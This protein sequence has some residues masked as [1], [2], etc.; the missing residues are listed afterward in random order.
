ML[1]ILSK[2]DYCN[3][4]YINLPKSQ[5]NC[6]QQIDNSL[7]STVVKAP[8]FSHI[9]PILRSPHWHKINKHIEYK[10]LSLTYKILTTS[11]A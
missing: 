3:S 5:I 7:A 2:L 10:H 9:T 6:L 4:L 1:T 8:K 11:Q